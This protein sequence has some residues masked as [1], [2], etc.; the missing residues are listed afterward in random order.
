MAKKDSL[1]TRGVSI[2]EKSREELKE[3]EMY[4][5]ILHN[6]DYTTQEFVVSVIMAVFHK[7]ASEA[8]RI[9]LDVHRSG[10]GTAGVYV[11]DIAETKAH[12]VKELAAAQE[13][14]L[15]CTVEKA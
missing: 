11:Y 15:K 10:K 5:V 2:Q 14:P 8:T 6:D 9:M 4:R 13:F 1:F 3:P 7:T 12:Q